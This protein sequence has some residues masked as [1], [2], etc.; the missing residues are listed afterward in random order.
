MGNSDTFKIGLCMAGAISAGAYTAGVMDYL[1]ESLEEWQKRKDSGAPDTPSHNVEIPVIGGA[2]AGGMTGIIAASAFYDPITP[3]QTLDNDIL[4][5]IKT[6]KFYHSWVDLIS[7]KMLN[8]LLDNS[9]ITKSGMKSAL[10]ADFIDKIAARALSVNGNSPLERKYISKNLKVFTTLS[11]LEGMDFSVSFKSN[12]FSKDRFLVT[13][14]SDFACF[15]MAEEEGEYKKDGWIPLN[16]KTG[17]NAE[18]AKNSAMATGAFPVGLPARKVEREGKYLND[19]EWFK[20]ITAKHKANSPFPAKY[21]TINVDG[22]MINNEPFERVSEI[23]LNETEHDKESGDNKND[24]KK[25]DTFRGTV[26]MIDPFPSEEDTFKNSDDLTS[27]IGNTLSA[28]MNQSCIKP[29]T[30]IDAM[31]SDNTSQFLIAP[32]RYDM[33]DGKEEV[34][35]GAY[36]IACGS[37][38]GFGG[39]ISKEFRIHDYFL[40]RMNCE[41]FLRD[42]FTVRSDTTNSIFVNGYAGVTNKEKF[43]SKN[44]KDKGF[45]IIP[46]FTTESSKGYMPTFANEKQYPSVSESFV[47]SYRKMIKG[48]V[49]KVLF[50][51][52]EY[53]RTQ[54]FLLWAGAKLL[55]NGKIADAVLDTIIKSLIDHKLLKKS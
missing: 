16:F 36:A 55:L 48:R 31:E 20:H 41:K 28:L 19:L 49:E 34:T 24:Y 50:N 10:N 8:L 37:L 13:N 44:E 35:E 52:A 9:D 4:S 11:N 46:I 23:I 42:H 12:C 26:L 30:L 5:E 1:I 6:N 38:G 29:S 54:K 18:L 32:V 45:Q 43:M 40:G 21:S 17:L 33:K 14:H 25:Y 51:I 39:F 15:M 7:E 22:G 27:V 47:Y 53:S 2:S 3:V